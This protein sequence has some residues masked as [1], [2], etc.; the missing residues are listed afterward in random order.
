MSILAD[1]RQATAGDGKVD[2]EWDEWNVSRDTVMVQSLE[3]KGE[4]VQYLPEG[5]REDAQALDE[6]GRW[7]QV[8]Y[9]GQYRRVWRP[10]RVAAD[11]TPYSVGRWTEWYGDYTW[12]PEEPFGYTT[13]HY[14]YW[15]S[16]NNY[17]YWAPP[18]VSVGV[19]GPFWG[20]GFSW[21]PGRVGWLHSD[22]SIGWFPL[23]PWEP[24]YANHWWGPG[25]FAVHNAGVININVNRYAF[26]NRAVFVN[27]GSF[28]TANNLSTVR[29]SVNTANLSTQFRG[30]PLASGAL[31][32]AA[33]SSSRFRFTSADPST[34]PSQSVTGRV[35]QNQT[36][37]SQAATGVNAGSIRQQVATTRTTT[38]GTTQVAAPRLSSAAQTGTASPGTRIE[39][40]PEGA[41]DL[42]RQRRGVGRGA[43]HY[44][45]GTGDWYGPVPY[46]TDSGNAE[47]LYGQY[48]KIFHDVPFKT[49]NGIGIGES[50]HRDDRPKP[51][52]IEY[53]NGFNAVRQKTGDAG[54]RF[55]GV[56]EVRCRVNQDEQG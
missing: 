47:W 53:G 19:G 33:T 49:G 48:G 1:N 26:A 39:S 9:Q 30:A 4:S 18:I 6:N 12:V 43:R 37:F 40:K 38:P 15:F 25:G 52:H 32:A 14:G 23:L 22:V 50:L 2:A 28:T 45:N 56:F 24:Y 41:F 36:R 27:Q 42:F 34:T 55:S 54:V 29:Q 11:W 21:Y 35:A 16:A 20:I 8:Y 31:G 44:R 51:W 3:T 7:E 17:W 13:C 10:T 46:R 5:I